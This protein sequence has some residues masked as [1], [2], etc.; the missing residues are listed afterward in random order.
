VTKGLLDIYQELLGL[1]FEE[2]KSAHVWHEEVKLFSVFD[3]KTKKVIGQ[4]YL[5][6]HPRD[7]KYGH[8]ACFG[9]I[10]GCAIGKTNKRQIPVA[11]MVAN[12]SKATKDKPAFLFHNELVTYFHEFGHVMHALCTEASLAR[13]SGTSVERDFVEAPSQMLENWCWEYEAVSRM[14][15]HYDDGKK[16]PSDI[17]GK[18]V[19]AKNANAGNHNKRQLVFGIF[20]QIIHT[21]SKIDSAKIFAHTLRD[22]MG[23]DPTPGTNFVASFGHM[24]GGYDATYYGY[25]YAEVYSADMFVS[26]FKKEG[27]F[28]P[29]VGVDYRKEI[30]APGGSRDSFISLERFLGRKPSPQA[31]LISKGLK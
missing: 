28:N 13:F 29:K 14:S 26:R 16:F 1:R 7:G 22:I 20:D 24:A 2:H 19:A 30:L 10:S 5:D 6:L 31:F 12:F 21:R 23:I 15:G 18:M 17:L 25:M 8:A 9:L 3:S 27:I 11:A 4:F